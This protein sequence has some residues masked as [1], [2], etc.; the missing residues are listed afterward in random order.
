MLHRDG[1]VGGVVSAV[2]GL[3]SERLPNVVR[4]NRDRPPRAA[5]DRR[6][7]ERCPEGCLVGGIHDGV[8]DEDHIEFA[9]EAQ[10][11]HVPDQVLALRVELPADSQHRGRPVGQ[12]ESEVALEMKG[13]TAA[14]GAKLQ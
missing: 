5:V 3:R 13:E 7:A 1:P 14:A 11:S 12:R 4:Q 2:I 6:R 10:R 8:V 9:A